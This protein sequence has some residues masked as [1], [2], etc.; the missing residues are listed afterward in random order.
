MEAVNDEWGQN[1][2]EVLESFINDYNYDS[3]RL[4]L[5]DF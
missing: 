1:W 2:K 5:V 3:L 4:A